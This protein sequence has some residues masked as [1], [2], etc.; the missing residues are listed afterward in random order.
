MSRKRDQFNKPCCFQYAEKQDLI[1]SKCNILSKL[2]IVMT[3]AF[4]SEHLCDACKE[5][6]LQMIWVQKKGELGIGYLGSCVGYR[7]YIIRKQL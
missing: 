6:E 2:H 4:A 1:L 3:F 7:L 5:K